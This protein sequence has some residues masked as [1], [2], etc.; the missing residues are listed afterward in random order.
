MKIGEVKAIGA[1]SDSTHTY[2][3]DTRRKPPRWDFLGGGSASLVLDEGDPAVM[4]VTT[5]AVG[6]H[7]GTCEVPNKRVVS[8]NAGTPLDPHQLGDTNVRWANGGKPTGSP[9]SV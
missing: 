9:I 1:T 7:G 8:G 5:T 3:E 2:Q 6:E 4:A